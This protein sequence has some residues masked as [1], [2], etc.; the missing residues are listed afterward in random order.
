MM[1]MSLCSI[2]K[3]PV[4]ARLFVGRARVR[5]QKPRKRVNV[6]EKGECHIM[7]CMPPKKKVESSV[8][9]VYTENRG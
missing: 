8:T 3:W 5:V 9:V 7:N 2:V 6:V 1:F 4:V